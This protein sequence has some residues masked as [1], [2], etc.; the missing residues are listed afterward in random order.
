M[1]LAFQ[2]TINYGGQGTF[3]LELTRHLAEKIEDIHIFPTSLSA[4]GDEIRRLCD[5]LPSNINVHESSN[6][7]NNF[8]NETRSFKNFDIVHINYAIPGLS[9]FFAKKLYD[10]PY[11]YTIHSP[12]DMF[13]GGLL[14]KLVY[15]T[16]LD[17]FLPI[18]SKNA[19]VV[20]VSKYNSEIIRH[21]YSVGTDVVYHGIDAEKFLVGDSSN[22]DFIIGQLGMDTDDIIILFVGRFHG[23][24][25]IPTLIKAMSKIVKQNKKVKLVMIGGGGDSYLQVMNDIKQNNIDNNVIIVSN[26]SDDDLRKYY[27]GADIFAFPSIGE[28]FGLVFLETMVSGLPIIAAN[29]GASPE[30]IGDAGLLFEPKNSDDLSNKIMELINNRELCTELKNKGLARAKEFTWEKA[31]EQYYKIYKEVLDR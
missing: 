11:V 8:M 5:D 22:R 15:M 12:P 28:G 7:I 13:F 31:A 24:K 18:V 23:Y 16:E 26:V 29:A 19:R 21:K 2:G 17:L 1:R 4:R 6:F 3:L 20:T 27:S 30:V 14:T 9:S 10:V 25:D